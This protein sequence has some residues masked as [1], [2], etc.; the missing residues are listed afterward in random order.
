MPDG[1]KLNEPRPNNIIIKTNIVF[2]QKAYSFCENPQNR[3]FSHVIFVQYYQR[4]L[5][6]M[7]QSRSVSYVDIINYSK[8]IIN[9]QNNQKI[10]DFIDF[11]CAICF[12][13][14]SWN[15]TM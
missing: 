6:L 13:Y 12:T 4:L 1:N 2:L 7:F 9:W 5:P 14:V 15:D 11:F 8:I 10:I 3:E